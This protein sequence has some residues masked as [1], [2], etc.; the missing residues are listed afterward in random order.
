M[1]KM[2]L[3]AAAMLA[4]AGCKE[5]EE[6]PSLPEKSDS[7]ELSVSEKIFDHQGGKAQIIVTSTGEWSAK[8]AADYDWVRIDLLSGNDGDVVKLNV[9]ANTTRDQKKA[10]FVFSCGKAEQTL[11]VVSNPSDIPSIELKSEKSCVLGYE[12]VKKFEVKVYAAGV[13]YQDFKVAVPEEAKKWLKYVTTIPGESDND[14]NIIFEVAALEGLEDRQAVITVSAEGTLAP[15]EVSVL[16]EAKH[17]L[18]VPPFI[19]AAMEGETIEVPVTSNVEYKIDIKSDAGTDWIK[20]KEKREGNEYFE[21]SELK[22]GK[23]TA[24][25]TLTQTDA[26]EGEEALTASFSVTQQEVLIHWAAEMTK[27][28]LFPKWEGGGPSFCTAFTW[29]FMFRPSDFDKANGSVLTLMG[30]EGEFLLRLG[31]VGNPLDHLQIATRKGNYNI[32]FTFEA[33]KWYHLAVTYQGAVATVYVD[34]KKVGSNQFSDAGIN[35]S[36]AWSY[37]DTGRRCLWIGYSYNSE[38]DFHGQM[39][40][41]RIWKKALTEEEINAEGHFYSVDPKSDGLFSYWKF[42]KGE[43]DTIEDATG[44]GNPLHG[45]YDVKKHR[46]NASEIHMGTKG[47]KYA[48]VSLP[49]K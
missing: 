44:N 43:G 33:G 45:E 26:K 23:R 34:G 7:I 1:K 16:Q 47:I 18:E 46:A 13:Y 17:V 39:T 24:T 8:P 49:E 20:H 2:L 15:V 21:V 48:A 10:E 6:A 9:N 32:P 27:N 40:E 4:F 42:T 30:I 38:R 28:R 31:D 37:E 22:G 19:T 3:F 36:P 11:K 35:L 14:A 5:E 41:I 29:E 25:V 12:F